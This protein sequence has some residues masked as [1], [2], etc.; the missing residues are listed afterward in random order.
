MVPPRTTVLLARAEVSL[1]YPPAPTQGGIPGS[2]PP[3]GVGVD[4]FAN[5]IRF[6][7]NSTPPAL[8]VVEARL[9][10]AGIGV[11]AVA[12]ASA[13]REALD[14]HLLIIVGMLMMMAVLM[15]V[16]GG[17]GLIEAMSISVLERR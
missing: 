6:T 4:G 1:H 15:S 9:G 13:G 16:V 12:T 14:D 2:N 3:D 7:R 17:L 5:H 10:E 11:V 8:A